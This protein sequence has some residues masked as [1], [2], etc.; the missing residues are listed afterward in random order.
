MALFGQVLPFLYDNRKSNK[1]AFNLCF[2]LFVTS[3][4]QTTNLVFP[5]YFQEFFSVWTVEKENKLFI[6]PKLR[7]NL[8]WTNKKLSS[9]STA[10]TEKNSWKKLGKTRLV[11]WWFDIMN[12]IFGLI[13]VAKYVNRVLSKPFLPLDSYRHMKS[14]GKYSKWPKSHKF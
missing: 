5:N 4:H 12:K 1:S 9:F 10:K 6:G 2:I 13:W 11:V 7:K 14:S 8:F 3:N